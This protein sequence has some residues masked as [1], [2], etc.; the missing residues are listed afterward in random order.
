MSNAIQDIASERA[1]QQRVEGY[2]TAHDDQYVSGRL[3]LGAAAYCLTAAKMR[4]I[5]HQ[6]RLWSWPRETFKPKDP[7]RDLVR[8][9]AMVVA[10]IERIDRLAAETARAAKIA[11]AAAKKTQ[12]KESKTRG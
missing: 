6:L 1:R 11:A 3:A 7:R 9:G 5:A 2:T 10:E 12:H 8:A 4:G